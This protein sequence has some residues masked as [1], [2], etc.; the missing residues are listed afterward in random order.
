MH[1][2]SKVAWLVTCWL[3]GSK[4]RVKESYLGK[5]IEHKNIADRLKMSIS[6]SDQMSE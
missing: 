4:P 5:Q 6:N 2:M 1:V 3:N